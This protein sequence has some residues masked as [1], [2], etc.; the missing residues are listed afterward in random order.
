MDRSDD[1]LDSGS[2]VP[3][4]ALVSAIDGAQQGMDQLRRGVEDLVGLPLG[5]LAVLMSLQPRPL[6]TATIVD[7]TGMGRGAIEPTLHDL[8]GRDLV[9]GGDPWR[10]TEQGTIVAEQVEGIRIRFAASFAA[11]FGHEVTAALTGLFDEFAATMELA[12]ESVVP[13]PERLSER[14]LG[15]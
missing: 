10:L 11:M 15:S 12:A 3:A 9:E 13:L 6:D 1:E 5:H 4:L 14:A 2:L 7:R 8:S